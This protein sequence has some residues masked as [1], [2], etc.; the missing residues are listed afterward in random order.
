[1]SL[2]KTVMHRPDSPSPQ[3][4]TP[5]FLPLATLLGLHNYFGELH[6]K[7]AILKRF[8]LISS[9]FPR[10]H[11]QG[12]ILHTLNTSFLMLCLLEFKNLTESTHSQLANT[13]LDKI[14]HRA[15]GKGC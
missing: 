6:T 12:R 13:V 8:C 9:C 4:P 1:M 14:P 7:Y 5:M 3:S 2:F 11:P 10:P 15:R